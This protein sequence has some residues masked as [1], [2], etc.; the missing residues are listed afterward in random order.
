MATKGSGAKPIPTF[1]RVTINDASEMPDRYS[2]TPGGTLFSTTPGGEYKRTYTLPLVYNRLVQLSRINQCLI[3]HTQHNTHTHWSRS[4]AFCCDVW[5][6]VSTHKTECSVHSN[7]G[8]MFFKCHLD[9]VTCTIQFV[10]IISLYSCTY[11]YV[12]ICSVVQIFETIF[13]YATR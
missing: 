1:R 6:C 9:K 7:N 8:T 13:R 2:Q 12:I 4:M 10:Q 11:S 5:W 3:T